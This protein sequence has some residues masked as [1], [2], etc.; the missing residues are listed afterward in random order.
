ML[1]P[2]TL[3]HWDDSVLRGMKA[4]L[5]YFVCVY[6]IFFHHMKSK[7]SFFTEPFKNF[8]GFNNLLPPPA[9]LWHGVNQYYRVEEKI[10]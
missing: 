3:I 4:P 8:V 7:K 10:H 6:Y 2:L 9:L 5:F 1:P